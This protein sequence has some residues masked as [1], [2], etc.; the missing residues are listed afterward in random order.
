M[1]FSA[2]DVAPLRSI[3][4]K[5]ESEE[6]KLKSLIGS[7]RIL[8]VLT[9]PARIPRQPVLGDHPKLARAIPDAE[10]S[11]RFAVGF[12]DS[13]GK[14][15]TMVQILPIARVT[16]LGRRAGRPR[17]GPTLTAARGLLGHF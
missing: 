6:K 17:H 14:R 9:L 2:P 10:G 13:V 1:E 7:P 5:L 12:A 16:H 11:V 8:L 3:S 15:P 4:N